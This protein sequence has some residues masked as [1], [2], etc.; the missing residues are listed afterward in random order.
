MSPSVSSLVWASFLMSAV[1]TSLIGQD[2]PVDDGSAARQ[3]GS[4]GPV[5]ELPTHPEQMAVL[6]SGKVLM[7]PWAPERRTP[8]HG[9]LALWNPESGSS[10]IYRGSGVESASGLAFQPDGVLL[11]AG[12][13]LP[14]GGIDGNARSFAFDYRTEELHEV[15]PMRRGRVFPSATTLP[16]GKILVSG[17]LDQGYEINAVPVLWDGA[18]WTRL[19]EAYNDESRGPTFQFVA[20][21]GRLFRAGPEPL[22]DWLDI[23]AQAWT[24]MDVALRN[25]VRYQGTAVMYDS[26]KIL[27]IGGCPAYRCEQAGPVATAEAIDLHADPPAW[28]EVGAMSSPRH[29]H[30]ATLLPDGTVLVTGGTDKPDVFNGRSDGILAAEL[31]DPMT[32]SF[33]PAAAMAAARHFQSA[34]VLLHDGRVLVAGGAFGSNPD[35]ATFAP[36]GQIYSPP[37]LH[38]GA[39]PRVDAVPS[40]VRY[41]ERFTLETPDAASISAVSLV[42]LSA[43][44]QGWNATQRRVRLRFA[45][46]PG[47]VR[48]EAPGDPNLAPPGFYLVFILNDRGVPSVGRPMRIRPRN[49]ERAGS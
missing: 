20:P 44:S 1:P 17:G 36:T 12:G 16:S 24:D 21:D 10:A 48:V 7:W 43:A 38:R 14:D 34:A 2:R 27:L 29:S 45:M 3:M 13:D 8:P 15:E 32:E 9:P 37:Y 23:E 49:E 18:T 25:E 4:W 28:R 11:S 42:A 33:E 46:A 22:S 30:H 6:P 47:I 5:V 41:G 39:R 19:P 35:D 31:W 40:A 26:G